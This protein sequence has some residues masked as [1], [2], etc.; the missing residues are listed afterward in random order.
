ML[1]LA[2]LLSPAE[3]GI[4]GMITLF[5]ALATTCVESGFATAL[6]Q[7]KEITEVDK[8]SVFFF[9]VSMGAVMALLLFMAA[10]WIAGFYRQPILLPLT[11]LMA[12]NLLIGSF[13]VVQQALLTRGLDFRTIFRAGTLAMLVSGASSVWM[14]WRGYGVWSLAAQSVIYTTV[15]TCLLWAFCAW[16]PEPRF[17]LASLAS[18]F[19]FGSRVLASG[20]LNT[21]F[22]RIQLAVIGKAFSAADLGFYTRAF[23][24]QQL[25]V[26]LL[27]SVVNRVTFPMF[28]QLSHDRPALRSAVPKALVSIMLVTMPIMLGMAAVARPLVLVLFGAKWLPCVPYLMVLSVAGALWPLH[29]INL[30]TVMAVGRSDLFLRMEIVKKVLI[31]VGLLVTF[32][33]SV[34]AMVWA[35]LVVGVI[36]VAVN[37]HYTKSLI[38]YGLWSQLRDL[39]PYTGVAISMAVVAWATSKSLPGGPFTQLAV[40]VL[41]S[42]AYYWVVCH[43]LRLKYYLSAMELVLGICG[44]HSATP[45][46]PSVDTTIHA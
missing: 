17:R 1:I 34:M 40:S 3:F 19:G 26:G 29:V 43:L 5:T 11:R 24:T 10:S 4:L 2:R 16:K 28:S 27:T 39:A 42:F 35:V 31:G 13:G 22:D 7:R 30:D 37:S 6:I 20:F 15:Q 36:C 32:R 45:P 44:R 9:N 25:P 18:L 33:I 23:S 41:V 12:L 46:P 14:A 21:F 38:E 8:S